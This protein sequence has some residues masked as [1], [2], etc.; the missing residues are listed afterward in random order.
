MPARLGIAKVLVRTVV[1][2]VDVVVVEVLV[3][4]DD[5]APPCT[6]VVVDVVVEVLAPED[7]SRINVEPL[8]TAEGFLVEP[9]SHPATNPLATVELGIDEVDGHVAVT[10]RALSVVV[11]AAQVIPRRCVGNVTGNVAGP[12]DTVTDNAEPPATLVPAAGD[13]VTM[14]P[15]F[16]VADAT[17]A[18]TLRVSPSLLTSEDASAR[19]SP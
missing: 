14:S 16:T 5:G 2:V 4:V 9:K 17:C 13:W 18:V 19:V 8:G 15:A 10:C 11:A 12:L 1:V 3:E 6:V 7:V